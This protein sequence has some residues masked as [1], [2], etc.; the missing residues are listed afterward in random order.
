MEIKII[1]KRVIL[2]KAAVENKKKEFRFS[3]VHSNY[4]RVI[5]GVV[6]GR[7]G[8]FWG[9]CLKST[10]ILLWQL[11]GPFMARVNPGYSNF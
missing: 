2:K 6:W 11:K 1:M 4:C 5:G 10:P 3:R 9:T 8:T 7:I